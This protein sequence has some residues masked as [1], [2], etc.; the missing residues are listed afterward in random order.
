MFDPVDP[1]RLFLATDIGAFWCESGGQSW[2]ALGADM[3]MVPVPDFDLEGC[4]L[5]AATFE[6]GMYSLDQMMLNTSASD[7]PNSGAVGLVVAPNPPRV[8]AT[9]RM[10]LNAPARV[11]AE[12]VN[13][14]GRLVRRVA[15]LE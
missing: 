4:T 13:V 6:R 1:Q 8:T 3:P 9:L 12:L 10:T 14:R 15:P 2:S 11:G 5:V 7:G